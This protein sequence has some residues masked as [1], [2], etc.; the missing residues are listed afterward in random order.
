VSASLTIPSGPEFDVVREAIAEVD[1]IHAAGAMPT[2]MVHRGVDALGRLGYF[3]PQYDV[4]FVSDVTPNAQATS[5]HETGHLVDYYG[6]GV[7]NHDYASYA[8][9]A[10]DDWRGAVDTSSTVRKLWDAAKFRADAI[11]AL[12][13]TVYWLDYP[14]LWARSYAQY[15]ATKADSQVV[16]SFLDTQTYRVNATEMVRLQWSARDFAPVAH[17]IDTMFRNLGWMP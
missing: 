17:A 9:P 15:I 12:N 2:I 7:S 16:L 13:L 6:L 11:Q 4:L 1:G 10:L 14:E 3:D 5:W 8:H